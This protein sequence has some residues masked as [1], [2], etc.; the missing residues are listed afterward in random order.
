MF[1]ILQGLSDKTIKIFMSF[2]LEDTLNIY[3]GNSDE[4]PV[5][6]S[7][8]SNGF[9]MDKSFVNSTDEQASTVVTFL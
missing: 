8:Y 7:L 4:S 2:A 9:L 3:S 5:D 1:L 6:Y